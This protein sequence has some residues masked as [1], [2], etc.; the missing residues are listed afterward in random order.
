MIEII[1]KDY[2]EKN[3]GY[4]VCFEKPPDAQIEYVLIEKIGSAENNHLLSAVFV[5]QSYAASLYGAALLNEKVK[6][7]VYSLLELPEISKV[8]LNSDYNFTDTSTKQYRYQAVF[9]I[10]H[11]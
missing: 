11:Y 8:K 1:I 3:L 9:D 6:V 5:F 2:L 4:P 7:A 10:N